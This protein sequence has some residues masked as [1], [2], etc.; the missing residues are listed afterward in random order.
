VIDKTV[1]AKYGC[2]LA[3]FLAGTLA[4]YTFE[5]TSFGIISAGLDNNGIPKLSSNKLKLL[6]LTHNM[7][8]S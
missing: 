1:A 7:D 3:S 5:K 8:L 2:D 4:E 6:F